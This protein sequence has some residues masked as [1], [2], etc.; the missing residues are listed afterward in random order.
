MGQFRPSQQAKGGL[1]PA[2]DLLVFGTA[3][4]VSSTT[5]MFLVSAAGALV[6]AAPELWRFGVGCLGAW[7]L[8]GTDV[9]AIGRGR[10]C[11][12]GP[13]RQTPQRLGRRS[14]Y[15]VFLWGLDV[16]VPFTTVRATGLPFLA[17][18]LL[19]I[20]VGPRWASPIYGA[21]FAAILWLLCLLPSPV[22]GGSADA[23]VGRLTA[24]RGRA[25]AGAIVL[26][27]GVAVLLT[28]RAIQPVLVGA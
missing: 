17:M 19:A 16:G 4:L 21:S 10:P 15:G 25:R 6:A 12:I 20:G 3:V 5:T 27:T 13:S 1:L 22:A 2:P 23:M 8:V 9:I 7:A 14:V 24:Q 11:A 26:A 18:G 28:V